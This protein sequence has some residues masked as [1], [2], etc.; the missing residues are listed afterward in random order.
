MMLKLRPS[1]GT[2]PYYYEWNTGETT[3][4]IT[5]NVNGPYWVIVSDADTCYSDTATFDVTFVSGTGIKNTNNIPES[6]F[7]QTQLIENR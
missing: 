3:A 7:I 4:A 1:N 5:P 2:A 6:I